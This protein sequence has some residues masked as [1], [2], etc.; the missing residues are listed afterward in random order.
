MDELVNKTLGQ[1]QITRELG[2][3][4]MAIVYE[5]FQPAL[6]RKVAIKVLLP[7]LSSDAA[8]VQRFQHEAIAAAS[9][10]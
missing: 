9:L 2:R 4:G 5:A 3:G 10:R 1:F 6:Q 7:S 8:F